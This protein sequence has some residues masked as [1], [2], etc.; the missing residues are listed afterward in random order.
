[1]TQTVC[2][3]QDTRFWQPGDVFEVACA[4]CGYEVE[5]FKDDGIRRCK[6]CGAKVSNP[7]LNLGCAQ[8]CEHAKECLGYDPKERLEEADA[9]HETLTDRLIGA[10]KLELARDRAGFAQAI[11]LL[12]LAQR[13]QKESGGSPKIIHTAALLLNLDR[14]GF[15]D[16]RPVRAHK[17]MNDLGLDAESIGFIEEIILNRE[18]LTGIDSIEAGVIRSALELAANQPG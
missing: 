7:K 3:G 5:F 14:G 4:E 2:P 13:L 16:G 8:W 9:V 6:G 18:D 17:I 10:L 11:T 1:M 15:E 12:D